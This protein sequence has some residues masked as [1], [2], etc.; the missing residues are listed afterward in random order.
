MKIAG[1]QMGCGKNKERNLKKALDLLA[2]AIE[3]EARIICFPENFQTFW[4]PFEAN[5]AHF[6][7]AE[8]ADG[9]TIS[10]IRE[11]TEKEDAVV[12]CPIFEKDGDGHYNTAFVLHKGDIIGRYRKLHIPSLPLWQEKFYFKPGDLGY[13][14]FSTPY[15]RIGVQICWDNFFPEG[16]R[17]LALKGAEMVFAPTACA[18]ASQS[19]WERAISANAQVNGIFVVRVNR[20]GREE[21]QH[22]YGKTFCVAPDGELICEPSGMNEGVVLFDVDLKQIEDVRKEWS[23]LNERR[24]DIYREI[25]SEWR[26]KG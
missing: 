16:V 18:F 4:F 7:L 23:F 13:P 5:P 2:I 20:V 24:E 26:V 19:K 17:I 6:G 25:L 15:G 1:I 11:F 21:K 10:S 9:H 22:F 12:I 3:K 14:V 8:T